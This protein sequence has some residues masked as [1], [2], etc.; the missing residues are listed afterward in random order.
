MATICITG[1]TDGIGRSAA[2]LLLGQGHRVLVH[3]RSEARG[4]PVVDELGRAG[5][6]ALVVGDLADLGQ[7]PHLADAIGEVDVL[8]HNAGIWARAGAARSAQ[9]F[10]P[11]FAVNVLAPHRLTALLQDRI[12]GRLVFL[13]SGM[14]GSGDA[15]PEHLGEATEPRRAY[16]DSKAL[17][18][19]LAL[20]WARR[21]PALRVGAVDPGWVR[22]KLAS[23]GA[24][25]EV[26]SGGRRVAE[27]AAGEDWPGGYTAGRRAVRVPPAL[28]SEPLQDAVLTALDRLT[29]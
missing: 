8:V 9:G 6:V 10:E 16:A 19:V 29:S 26:G 18:V 24:P 2:E 1:S 15:D 11:T 7:L 12:R 4:R 21:L 3:A 28:E 27:A 17:D 22:T 20:G 5:E 13:G 23:P 25:G 14:A